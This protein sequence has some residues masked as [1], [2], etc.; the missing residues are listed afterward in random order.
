MT[1]IALAC[2]MHTVL[3]EEGDPQNKVNTRRKEKGT[4]QNKC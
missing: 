3:V 2:G 4:G 1:I